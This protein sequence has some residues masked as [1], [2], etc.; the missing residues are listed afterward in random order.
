MFVP[1]TLQNTTSLEKTNGAVENTKK[2][3][4]KQF[5]VGSVDVQSIKR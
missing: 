2:V 1:Q 4:S 3:T 5:M